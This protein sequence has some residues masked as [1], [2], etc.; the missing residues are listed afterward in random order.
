MIDVAPKKRRKK[1]VSPTKLTLDECKRR[2]WIAQVVEQRIPRCFITRDLFGCIDVLAMGDG[3]T[4]GI[5]ATGATSSGNHTE[6][7]KKILAEPRMQTWLG[8]ENRLLLWSWSLRGAAGT[9]KL[10][11]LREEEITVGMFAA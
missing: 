3:R 5:Q 11:T 6:R 9:R 1:R 4:I 10:W 2:G 7:R 8:I